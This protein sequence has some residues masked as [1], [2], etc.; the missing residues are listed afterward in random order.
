MKLAALWY[1]G[2]LLVALTGNG[3]P[4]TTEHADMFAAV[5]W[6]AF[7]RVA[8]VMGFAMVMHAGGVAVGR[9]TIKAWKGND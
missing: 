9:M 6:V 2:F 8:Q 4:V 1:G 5:Q 7:T 3:V